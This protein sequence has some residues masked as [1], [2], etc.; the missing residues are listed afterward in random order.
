MNWMHFGLV[1]VVSGVV[2]SFTDWLF[3]GVLFHKKYQEAPEAWRSGVSETGKIV[4][5]EVV[6]LITCAAFA[7]L[8]IHTGCQTIGQGLLTAGLVWLAGP[9][10]IGATNLLWMRISPYIGVSHALGWLARL[11]L[12][13]I[14]AAY[15]P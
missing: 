5:S 11:V 8:L 9:V 6:G 10:A 14:A 13:A 3:M 4:W 1:V 2:A 7:Y 15:L 12:V